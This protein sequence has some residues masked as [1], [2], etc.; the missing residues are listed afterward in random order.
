MIHKIDT[1]KPAKTFEGYE[2]EFDRIDIDACGFIH[3]FVKKK[4]KNNSRGQPMIWYKDGRAVGRK[5]GHSS[6]IINIEV[7]KSGQKIGSGYG[8]IADFDKVF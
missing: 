1:K 6:G 8:R 7:E 3:G 2:V 5:H 4:H